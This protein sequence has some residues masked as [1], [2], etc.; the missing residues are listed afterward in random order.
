MSRFVGLSYQ[1]SRIMVSTDAAATV[2]RDV[3][4]NVCIGCH[5]VTALQTK[6][7]FN[8]DLLR[9]HVVAID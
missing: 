1:G 7:L 3:A 6:R 2:C 8:D 9:L 5:S 4:R